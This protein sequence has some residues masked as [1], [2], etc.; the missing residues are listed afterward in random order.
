[1]SDNELIF[2]DEGS[3]DS[4][5]AV[6]DSRHVPW[7]VL[8]V[9]DE[10]QVHIVTRMVLGEFSFDGR[11]LEIIH[12][13]SGNEAIELFHK[14]RD[15]AICLLD[16]VMETDTAGLDVVRQVRDKIKNIYTRI[17]LRTGQPGQ[18]P[19]DEVIKELDIND[20]KDKTELTHSKLH[21]LIYS[22]LRSYRDI[23]ALD[24]TRKGLEQVIRASN[25]VFSHRFTG[26]FAQGIL[27]QF[28]SLMQ[29]DEHA[30]YAIDDGLAAHSA[31]GKL[32]IVEGIGQ[33]DQ[34]CGDDLEFY[35]PEEMKVQLNEQ[36]TSFMTIHTENAFL[37]S[38]LID[39]KQKNILYLKKK[40]S[41][42]TLQRKILDIFSHNVL[43][44]FQNLYLLEDIEKAQREMVYLLAES[45][46]SRSKETGFHLKRVANLSYLLA[47]ALGVDEDMA[48]K[49]HR[50][51]PLHDLGKVAIP[52][53]ILN[54]PGK[55]T[56]DEFEIMKTHAQIGHDIIMSSEQELCVTG[57]MIALEHHERWDGNGYPNGKKGNEISV[58]GRI[59]AVADVFDALTCTRCYKSAWSIDDV[60]YYMRENS[61][62]QF[63]PNII[64]VLLMNEMEVRQ[65]Y[66]QYS[67]P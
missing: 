27:Q 12:A 43:V 25:N 56:S 39:K 45:I 21:T 44:A 33:F 57:R 62:S 26:E 37:A 54:K 13:Y 53:A 60:F 29:F 1:M 38:N 67:E 18:A 48:L 10:E 59:T 42:T 40:G 31:K 7:K 22:C 28:S 41:S 6:L 34:H 3:K 5:R 23:I 15:I 30:A 66:Q 11:Q 32:L 55:L 65:I 46:E 17:V 4:D 14:Y 50:A 47:S 51:S 64:D 35:L 58:E 36:N 49:I 52:D 16:V 63:D 9:D 8:V 20:Y 19:E 24:N 2:L 61:G